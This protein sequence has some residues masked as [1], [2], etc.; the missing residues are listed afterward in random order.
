EGKLNA[1]AD[2]V[3]R[4][5][6]VLKAKLKG[7]INAQEVDVN[8]GLAVNDINVSVK[9]HVNRVNPLQLFIA[10][11]ESGAFG[12]NV[13]LENTKPSTHSLHTV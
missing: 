10:G 5:N 12:I 3:A 7:T 6:Q 11:V 13:K 1:V 9:T 2:V 8:G 4:D